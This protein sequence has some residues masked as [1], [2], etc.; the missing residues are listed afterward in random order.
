MASPL[1]R[2]PP[3]PRQLTWKQ[4]DL[5]SNRLVTITINYLT[6]GSVRMSGGAS[7]LEWWSMVDS[8]LEGIL[9]KHR[10]QNCN[11]YFHAKITWGS[12]DIKTNKN[13]RFWAT[14]IFREPLQVA[15][16]ILWCNSTLEPQTGTESHQ[17]I[18][19]QNRIR[20]YSRS[21]SAN[22]MQVT[23]IIVPWSGPFLG[24]A[25]HMYR[26]CTCSLQSGSRRD[27]AWGRKSVNQ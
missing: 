8:N 19:V 16:D 15:S 18:H 26:M 23:M 3:S 21:T 17:L 4:S 22:E 11:S 9:H 27:P 7:L 14:D 13:A 25:L 20:T 5:R 24:T 10:R 1:T 6:E 2:K 12:F